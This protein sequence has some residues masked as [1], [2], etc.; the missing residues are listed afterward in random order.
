[1]TEGPRRLIP[2]TD[3][4]AP[5][6]AIGQEES[7]RRA[8][9]QLTGSYRTGLALAIADVTGVKPLNKDQRT[10]LGMR[11]AQAI[12]SALPVS[13]TPEHVQ[14]VAASE[15]LGTAI[16]QVTRVDRFR[17]LIESAGG[18]SVVQNVLYVAGDRDNR[19]ANGLDNTASLDGF[20]NAAIRPAVLDPRE[21]SEIAGE[22][23]VVYQSGVTEG[24]MVD[25]INTSAMSAPGLCIVCT[26]TDL[27]GMKTFADSLR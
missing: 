2:V 5:G 24:P 27:A 10:A 9:D 6:R 1:M 7:A 21:I 25:S 23:P 12:P 8:K 18:L 14:S 17:K 4:A 26:A 3:A 16:G 22:L 20:A 19:A 15:A 11:F 13:G